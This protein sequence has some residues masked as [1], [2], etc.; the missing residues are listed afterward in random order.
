MISK[1]KDHIKAKTY[2]TKGI[3]EIFE[4]NP[5]NRFEKLEDEVT[6]KKN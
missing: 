3:K 5:Q 6:I 2:K 4:I 1:A